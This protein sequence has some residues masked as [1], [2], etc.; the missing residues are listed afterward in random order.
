MS[1]AIRTVADS[2]AGITITGLDIKDLDEIPS[3]VKPR[4]CPMIIPA[5]NFVSTFRPTRVDLTTA[6]QDY[7]YTLVYRLLSAPV[8]SGRGIHEL[9]DTMVSNLASFLDAVVTNHA[10]TGA[11]DI[12]AANVSV[13]GV[14]EGPGGGSFHGC[15]I[16]IDVLE[17]K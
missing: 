14:V 4:D 3:V 5:P 17:F 2:I 9:Y 12:E 6:E 15:D 13:F 1:L 7:E 10:V 8:G 11:V 16:Y